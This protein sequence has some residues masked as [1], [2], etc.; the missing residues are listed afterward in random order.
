MLW[1]TRHG[2]IISADLGS[3]SNY[4]NEL[5]SLFWRLNIIFE[6]V[7]KTL[8]SV[9]RKVFWRVAINSELVGPKCWAKAVK[10]GTVLQVTTDTK[11]KSVNIPTLGGLSSKRKVLQGSQKDSRLQSRVASWRFV[12]R[13]PEE[14]SFLSI[15]V[16][17]FTQS[18]CCQ[19]W[20]LKE[21][22]LG[23]ALRSE[24]A[25]FRCKGRNPTKFLRT[26]RQG[27]QGKF[28]GAYTSRK[29]TF[30]VRQ[31]YQKPHQVLVFNKNWINKT[32]WARE[33]GKT[34]F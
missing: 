33:V 21:L 15:N 30:P 20:R 10:L 4:S 25:L 22:G 31:P 27:Q 6:I 16:S 14:F 17:S 8:K 24:E 11:G 19:R 32:K 5:Q 28:S 3:S 26:L 12:C 7:C 23:S 29:T 34:D 13:N 2:T 9:V 1:V 18:C